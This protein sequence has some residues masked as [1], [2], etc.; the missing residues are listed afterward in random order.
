MFGLRS[1]WMPFSHTSHIYNI[2]AIIT[3]IGITKE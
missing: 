2:V 1:V 3:I